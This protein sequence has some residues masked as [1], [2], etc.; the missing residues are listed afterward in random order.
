MADVAVIVESYNEGEH[1]SVER[2][3][4]ALGAA[5]REARAHGSARVM[6]ADSGASEAVVGLLRDRFPEV[7]RVPAGGAGYDMAKVRAAQA[8]GTPIVAYLDGDCIP[9]EG[10]L[11]ELVRPI[12]EGRAV[13]TAGFT[14]YEG[15]FLP[16]VASVLDFGFLLPVRERPVGCYAS[17]NAAFATETL[18]AVPPEGELRSNC[19]HHAQA[20]ERRGTPMRLV[21]GARVQHE[22]L[23]I[24]PERLRRGWDLVAAARQDPQLP[25]ARWLRLGLLAT[26]L[27]LA[28]NLRYDVRRLFAGGAD[29][30]LTGVRR[31]AA[32]PLLAAL[33]IVDVR[34]IVAALRGRP[35][36]E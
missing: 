3:A 35:V 11:T 1:S 29:L 33:R 19:F 5:R 8:A 16:R 28:Q 36:P 9:A 12:E 17:N 22:F 2:L 4:Q 25:E 21:P 6:L 30:G 24:V 31:L 34:G 27:F 10:W 14:R 7:E 18:V 26:P 32:L 23:P 20:L 15:G 13:A